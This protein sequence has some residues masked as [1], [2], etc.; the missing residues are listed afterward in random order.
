MMVCG[1]DGAACAQALTR[2]PIKIKIENTRVI[3][4]D[5]TILLQK[6]DM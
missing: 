1:V 3:W 4:G 2:I 5:I 6:K